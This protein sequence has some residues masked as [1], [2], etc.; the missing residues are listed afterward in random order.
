ME[1]NPF[2]E[3]FY[4][5]LPPLQQERLRELVERKNDPLLL[6]Y[7]PGLSA[8][9]ALIWA[10]VAVSL[11][12]GLL[13]LSLMIFSVLAMIVALALGVVIAK[14]FAIRFPSFWYLHPSF[15]ISSHEDTIQLYPWATLQSAS[16]A[17]R[18]LTLCFP[19]RVFTL[20][21]PQ[22]NADE[23]AAMAQDLSKKTKQP[24]GDWLESL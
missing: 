19:G 14:I 24:E 10:I 7:H 6:P 8:G 12:P 20:S 21:C 13:S 4:E 1:T 18:S 9:R 15:F 22:K 5:Y 23:F 3:Y 2:Q 11:L 17:R 16:G